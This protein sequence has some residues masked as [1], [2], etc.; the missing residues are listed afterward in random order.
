MSGPHIPP[1]HPVVQQPIKPGYTTTEFWLSF[2][3][4]IFAVLTILHPGFQ[5]TTY[6]PLANALATIAAAI[7]SGWYASSRS[8]MKSSAMEATAEIVTAEM[9]QLRGPN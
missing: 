2:A 1:P 7:A 8:R 5:S 4:A 6:Q 3:P 9:R